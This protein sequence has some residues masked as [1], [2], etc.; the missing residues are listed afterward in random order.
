MQSNVTVIDEAAALELETKIYV[1]SAEEAFKALV[2]KV[3]PR[4]WES[5]IVA[6]ATVPEAVTIAIN[7]SPAAGV[8]DADA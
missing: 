8:N 3:Q 6:L 2:T 5:D 4:L 1:V 7:K